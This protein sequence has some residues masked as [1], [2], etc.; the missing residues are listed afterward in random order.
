M[1]FRIPLLAFL[2][3]TSIWVN[4]Q[5]SV[6]TIP[7]KSDISAYQ[8]ETARAHRE[9]GNLFFNDGL[10]HDAI[11]EYS[12]AI[13]VN[14]YDRIA[15]Y[16]R[17]V[18]KEMLEDLPGAIHDLT[19]ILKRDNGFVSA[20]FLRGS[21]YYQ[22]EKYRDA[23]RDFTSILSVRPNS[24]MSYRKRGAVNYQ[25]RDQHGA[26]KDFNESIR[27]NPYDPITF[28]DRAVTRQYLGD[29]KGA[30]ADQQKVKELEA[31]IA[32]GLAK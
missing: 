15:W 9:A 13:E 16:N 8:I 25:M 21:Y 27:L 22:Q 20:Y 19:E 32:A 1:N 24:A 23:R 29:R 14:P 2:C 30:K 31:V 4:A 12:K 17:A 10:Y 3:V 11:S 6:D 26:L 28:H 5:F 18:S 7:T